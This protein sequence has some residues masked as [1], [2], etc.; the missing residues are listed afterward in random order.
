MST[1]TDEPGPE[2]PPPALDPQGRYALQGR[3]GGN[4]GEVWRV[5]DQDLRRPLLMKLLPRWQSEEA[6]ARFVEEAQVT[7]QLEHPGVVPVHELGQLPDGQLYYTM[8]EVRGRPFSQVLQEAHAQGV[9][10]QSLRR[11]VHALLRAC[12][13]VAYAHARGVLH[14]D[15]KP[16]NIVVGDFG[17]VAVI[18][19]GLARLMST[20]LGALPPVRSARADSGLRTQLGRVAG[21]PR[22]MAPEQARG[23]LHR[24]GPP[25]DVYA[26]GVVLFEVLEG[27]PARAGTSAEE[28]VAAAARAEAL[29]PRASHP[30]DLREAV[31]RATDPEPARRFPEAGALAEELRAWLDGARRRERALALVDRALERRPGARRLRRE[32]ARLREQ[33][34]ELEATLPRLAEEALRRPVWALEDEAEAAEAAAERE[35]LA[36]LQELR[37]ALSLAPEL[38][39]AHAELA[40]HYKARHAEAEASGDPAAAGFELLL[41]AHGAERHAD[42]LRGQGR[43]SLRPEPPGASWRLSR[44]V[45]DGRRLSP[46][47]EREGQGPIEQLALDRGS[48]LLELSAPGYAPARYP[49]RIEREAHWDAGGVPLLPAGSLGPDALYVPGGPFR[50]GG[51]PEA[52]FSLPAGERSLPG[53]VITRF[54]VTQREFIAFLDALV[55]AGR[56]AEALD[57]APRL[58]SPRPDQRGALVHGRDA[59]GH[60]HLSPDAEGDVWDPEWPVMQVDWHG[61]RAYAAWRAA[62]DGLPWR[63]PSELEW[64]KA[65]RGV[66]GR[67]WP[68]GEHVDPTWCCYKASHPGRPLPAVVDSFPVDCSVYGLRGAAGNQREWC[69]ERFAQGQVGPLDPDAEDPDAERVLR[70]GAFFFSEAATRVCCRFGL[71]QRARTDSVSF[72]LARSLG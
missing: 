65:A 60:F 64:E 11:L 69:L 51:D 58:H 16:A 36:G 20:A 55:D 13:A 10:G 7:A 19:W 15:L 18:D 67:R 17:E 70:G 43:L 68:W 24:L 37:A 26:L 48:W 28:L 9:D 57:A 29:E 25:S 3:L 6:V 38:P 72:R 5:W 66:D 54:Q 31:L 12:E 40:D 33:A 2:G 52:Y 23:E 59:A 21:T 41:R 45:Q 63:L 49:F 8:K 35:S 4:L 56:E 50:L 46:R 62:Q 14:R 42:Y 47:L 71:S 27:R 61:A 34:S 39:E 53:F 22:Y 30:Q 44:F 32:A 1:F